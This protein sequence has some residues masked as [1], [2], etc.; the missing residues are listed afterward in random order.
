MPYQILDYYLLWWNLRAMDLFRNIICYYCEVPTRVYI[1]SEKKTLERDSS[2][3]FRI[4][5]WKL[6]F[7]YLMIFLNEILK[8]V[9]PTCTMQVAIERIENKLNTSYPSYSWR[10]NPLDCRWIQ[11]SINIFY[12]SAFPLQVFMSTLNLIL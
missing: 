2:H 1:L 6:K 9:I 11:F 12:S 8:Q 3:F 4:F 5:W 7:L 10:W